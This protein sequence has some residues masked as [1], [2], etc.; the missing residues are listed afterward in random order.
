MSFAGNIIYRFLKRTLIHY[1]RTGS[2][3]L[4]SE[5]CDKNI[6]SILPEKRPGDYIEK[7]IAHKKYEQKNMETMLM[8][9]SFPEPLVKG[10]TLFS[11]KWHESYFE[12]IVKETI[13]RFGKIDILVHS[14]ANA[15]VA[16]S[17]NGEK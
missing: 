13:A 3:L 14:L 11:K 15:P 17:M 10:N 4:L 8:L 1:I 7:S 6:D 5:L 16:S 12:R 2:P 9:G